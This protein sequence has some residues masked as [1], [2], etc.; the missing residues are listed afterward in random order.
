METYDIFLNN[1]F[2]STN[3]KLSVKN[4]YLNETFAEVCVAEQ[5]HVEL[6]I[7]S[8]LEAEKKCKNLSSYDKHKALMIIAEYIEKNKDK[9]TNIIAQE[10]GKPIKFSRTEVER[11]IQTF[12]IAA[13]E[14]K[15][16]ISEY[17]I[18]DQTLSGINKEGKVKGF[19]VGLVAGITPFNF[20]LNLAVHKIA[21]AIAVGCPIILKPSSQTPVSVLELAKS[22][23]KSG[24]PEGAVS[25]MPMNRDDA[26]KL[27]TDDRIKKI[28]FTGSGEIGWNM[29]AKCGRK[30]ITLELGGNAAAVVCKDADMDNALNKCVAGA[31]AYSGQ[32]CIHTQRIY[33]HKEIF[34]K[35]LQ[36]FTEKTATLLYGDPLSAQTDI[37]VLIDENEAIRVE[38]W[39]KDAVDNGAKLVSGG[40]RKGAYVEPTILTNTNPEMKVWK[41]EIFGPVVI[42]ESFETIEE[43]VEKTNNSVYGLQAGI[44]TDSLSDINYAFNNI[45]VGGLMVNE[46]PTF[47]IDNMPYGGIKESGFG[48]EGVKYAMAEMTEL[49]LMVAPA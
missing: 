9:F 2:V 32:V 48:R 4:K 7:Q 42:I 13:E 41:D 38:Q 29:K 10:A 8:G 35:F 37:S 23:S 19:P 24:L 14:S 43:A 22:I 47:R 33:V 3:Q 49:K 26:N 5:E 45:E 34:D 27:I 6:A 11:A 44:F 20:P 28:S 18:L 39:V 40:K 25:L 36:K 17:I 1:K 12:I 30:R 15:K 16:N 46:S 21:P 31:F